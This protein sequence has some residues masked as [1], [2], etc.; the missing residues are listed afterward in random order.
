[1]SDNGGKVI[2]KMLSENKSIKEMSIEKLQF[3]V[4]MSED[5]QKFITFNR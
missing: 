4:K 5:I 2:M 3:T 1:M